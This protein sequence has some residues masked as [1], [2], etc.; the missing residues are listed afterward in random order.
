MDNLWKWIAKDL[1]GL[2]NKKSFWA[3]PIEVAVAVPHQRNLIQETSNGWKSDWC[4]I[5]RKEILEQRNFDVKC[6]KSIKWVSYTQVRGFEVSA[7][8]W[9]NHWHNHNPL[10][11]I[12]LAED[13]TELHSE[14]CGKVAAAAANVLT[15]VD[16]QRIQFWMPTCAMHKCCEYVFWIL[17]LLQ[18]HIKPNDLWQLHEI[19]S[20]D[21]LSIAHFSRLSRLRHISF[22]FLYGPR[23]SSCTE[24]TTEWLEANGL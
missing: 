9:H 24:G 5:E 1:A 20:K 18:M 11:D 12:Q 17:L 15:C 23:F 19:F 22:R 14:H 13:F 8:F 10:K 16:G 4:P 3:D 2:E 21:T 7:V 6:W